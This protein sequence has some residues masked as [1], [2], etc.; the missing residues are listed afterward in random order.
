MSRTLASETRK[1]R[2][3]RP[4][5]DGS[6]SPFPAA[7]R[8]R[9]WEAPEGHLCE[10]RSGDMHEAQVPVSAPG[11]PCLSPS[12]WSS[13]FRVASGSLWLCLSLCLPP[14]EGTAPAPLGGAQR[15][16]RPLAG[17]ADGA[18]GASAFTASAFAFVSPT[19]GRSETG[20]TDSDPH[21]VRLRSGAVGAGVGVPRAAGPTAWRGRSLP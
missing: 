9:G 5:R 18:K 1:V 16:T 14:R 15:P 20:G 8:G 7:N 11:R 12:V 17:G 10:Q 2:S 21:T 4:L 6:S 3:G 19:L 13:A